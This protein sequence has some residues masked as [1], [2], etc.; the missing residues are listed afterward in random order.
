[1]VIIKIPIFTYQYYSLETMRYNY[2]IKGFCILL[3]MFAFRIS[4]RAQVPYFKNA[5]PTRAS[6][7]FSSGMPF[8]LNA[9]NGARLQAFYPPNIFGSAVPSSGVNM[10]R[11]YFWADSTWADTITYANL[12]ITLGEFS[13][14]PSL[15][16]AWM[17]GASKLTTVVSGGVQINA[18]DSNWFYI[19]FAGL[20]NYDPSKYLMVDIMV[21]SQ[22]P[23]LGAWSVKSGPSNGP[24]LSATSAAAGTPNTLAG[25]SNLPAIG[26]DPFLGFNN[27]AL[28]RPSVGTPCSPNQEA[29]V[30]VR[31]MGKNVINQVTVNW[32][33]NGFAQV[34]VNLQTPIDTFGSAKNDTLFSLGTVNVAT[35]A[36][37]IVAWTTSPNSSTDPDR[38]NDTA[39]FSLGAPLNGTYPVGTGVTG[40]F[41]NL[42]SAISA[43]YTYGVCGPVTFLLDTAVFIEQLQFTGLVT[44]S[45]P[46]NTITFRGLDRE[47]SVI[48]YGAGVVNAKHVIKMQAT[49]YITFRNLTIRSLNATYGWGIHLLD[50]CKFVNVKGCTFDNTLQA[51]STAANNTAGISVSGMPTGLC[52]PGP[53]ATALTAA[54]RADSLEIDSNLFLFGYEAI[55]ITGNTTTLRGRG[56]KIR[57]NTILNAYQNSI[58]MVGQ[59]NLTVTDNFIVPRQTGAANVGIFL[60]A[61]NS[62]GIASIS[63]ISNNRIYAYSTAGISLNSCIGSDSLQKG[64]VVNNLIGGKEQLPDA[65]PI[66]ITGCKNWSVSHNTLHRDFPGSAAITG[67]CVRMLGTT[68]NITLMNNILAVTKP[69]IAIPVHLLAANNT[70][71]MNANSFFRADTSTNNQLINIAGTGYTIANYKGAAGFNQASAWARPDF[72]NDTNLLLRSTCGLPV[73]SRL[74]YAMN[75]LLGTLRPTAPLAGAHERVSPNNNLALR[76]LRAPLSPLTT[77]PNQVRILVQ[78]LGGNN[79]SS[80]TVAYR[81]NS[82]TP[83]VQTF[84]PGSP[85][86]PCDTLQVQFTNAITVGVSDTLCDLVVYSYAPN[87]QTDNDPTNDTLRT[88]LTTPLGG[89]YTIGGPTANFLNFTEA[90]N[91]LRSSGIK[92]SVTFLVNPGVYNEQVTLTGPLNGMMAGRRIVFDGIDTATRT[93]TYAGNT[94]L[95]HTFR[96]ENVPY[97]TL[98]NLK[99]NGE[100]TGAGWVVQLAGGCSGTQ[101][102]NCAIGFTGAGTSSTA[103]AFLGLSLSGATLTTAVKAD[104]I[105]IDSN[106]FRFGY[107]AINLY[108]STSL[109]GI[110]NKI[111]NNRILGAQQYS[112]YLVYQ[113]TPEITGNEIICRGATAG[114]GIYAQNVTT[115]ATGT[116]FTQISH[117]R[118]SA[119]GTAGIYL[120]TCTNASASLKGRMLNNAVGGQVKLAGSNSIYATSSTNWLICNN[121]INHDFSPTTATTAAAIRLVGAASATFGITLL[122]NVVAVMG[123][124]TALPLYTQAAGNVDA[125]DYN[126]FYRSDTTNSLSEYLGANISYTA[127]RGAGNFNRN[128]LYM[129]PSFTSSSNPEPNPADSFSWSMNG[130]GVYLPYSPKDIRQTQRPATNWDGVP[131]IGAF[132]F[133]PTSMPPMAKAIPDTSYAYGTQYFHYGMDTV[134]RITWGPTVPGFIAVRQY[135][136]VL[137]YMPDLTKNYMYFYTSVSSCPTGSLTLNYRDNWV[138]THTSETGIWMEQID[139]GSGSWN[140]FSYS[141]TIDTVRNTMSVSNFSVMPVVSYFSGT[142]ANA[143]NLPVKL[144]GFTGNRTEFKVDLQW[145]SASEQNFSG[146]EVERSSDGQQFTSVGFVKGNGNTRSVTGYSFLDQPNDELKDIPV[147]YYRLKMSDH[148]GSFAYSSTLALRL[149]LQLAAG[150]EVGPN[151]FDETLVFRSEV[152]FNGGQIQYQL[153]DLQ[154]A[155]I[156]EGKVAAGAGSTLEALQLPSLPAGCYFLS[157]SYGGVQTTH[158]LIKSN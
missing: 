130:R 107:Y 142:N 7:N 90:V 17:T 12:T 138:G 84:T 122:N 43:L 89:V 105:E 62:T 44:G 151:P 101:V 143:A 67:S 140:I 81:F 113:Q 37:D 9:T 114:V 11:I 50:T 3:L 59:D 85:L 47:K 116:L 65:N 58:N 74:G 145:K 32:T 20:Y 53:C 39:R 28:D 23:F 118:I 60:N 31:N 76:V 69:G 26:M 111:R 13:S 18:R 55:N 112:V 36:V 48:A 82:G 139:T 96:I 73:G 129:R 106:T 49:A 132:E 64:L 83:V 54:A 150:I 29:L 99:I 4:V 42:G 41:S 91:A 21:G 33:I 52:I 100:G 125:M 2:P 75:D 109:I 94:G 156:L 98:R 35:G 102:K 80:F 127:F 95:P 19:D 141:S 71:S 22:S 45:S 63:S 79:I 46:A 117:N 30:R 134:A 155:I 56:N 10:S 103:N 15:G 157:Y 24:Y 121:T 86:A 5:S 135:S 108:G 124:G 87:G 25:G 126:L 57:G 14:A 6:A 38:T 61:V 16:F 149:N 104:S 72:V 147:L 78:N 68:T 51:T 66:Y 123:T 146:Y 137:P 34:P 92:A 8:G 1:M 128:S 131:D 152:P 88:K 120:S 110:G 154:G 144:L 136:G 70:D 77:G 93:L 97:V 153:T 119:Y 158:K 133:T 148:D 27:A 40:G 115:L